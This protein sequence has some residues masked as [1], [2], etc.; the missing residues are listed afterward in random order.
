MLRE[1]VRTKEGWGGLTLAVAVLLVTPALAQEVGTTVLTVPVGN[2][3]T[4]ALNVAEPMLVT[5]LMAVIAF[6]LAKVPAGIAAL[7]GPLLSEQIL[8]RATDFALNAVAGAAK[9]KTVSVDVGNQVVQAALD[10]VVKHA[11]EWAAKFDTATLM[12]KIIARLD[13]APN[14]KIGTSGTNIVA[15]PGG[16]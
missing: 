12:Q 16:V 10:Y 4:D 7:V 9:D 11:P 14:A 13:L 5:L 6:V 3:L 2:W 1:I 8:K 15:T